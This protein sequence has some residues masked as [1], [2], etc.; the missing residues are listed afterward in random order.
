MTAPV[1]ILAHR[2]PYLAQQVMQSVAAA[3][4]RQIFLACDGP[5]ADR[6]DEFELVAATR[7]ALEAGITWDARVERRYLEENLGCRRAVEAAI[8]WFFE[9]VDSGII[10]EEDCLPNQDFFAFCT[11][12]LERFADE[13]SVMQIAGDNSTRIAPSVANADYFFIRRTPIWGWATWRRAWA[14]YDWGLTNFMSENVSLK[15]VYANPRERQMREQVLTKIAQGSGLDSWG[16]IW[17]WSVS[18]SFG[19]SVVPAVNLVSNI[20][21]GSDATHTTASQDSRSAVPTARIMPLRHPRRIRPSLVAERQFIRRAHGLSSW[22]KVPKGMRRAL[23]V[24]LRAGYAVTNRCFGLLRRRRRLVVITR[25]LRSLVGS[26]VFSRR[27]GDLGRAA[28]QIRSRHLSPDARAPRNQHEVLTDVTATAT[29]VGEAHE[30]DAPEL[31]EV[32]RPLQRFEQC[33]VFVHGSWADGTRTPF[34]DLDNLILINDSQLSSGDRRRI[35]VALAKV[36]LNMMRRDPLQHHGNWIILESD[37]D[38]LDESY[39]PLHVLEGALCLQGLPEVHARVPVTSSSE[40][41]RRNVTSLA[42][43]LRLFS[44]PETM[45]LWNAKHLVSGLSLMP[46]YLHQVHGKRISKKDALCAEAVRA[47][48]SATGV[49]AVQWATQAR[50]DW[51]QQLEREEFREFFARAVKLQSGPAIRKFAKKS[52]PRP[53]E[54]FVRSL[55]SPE[56]EA[57]I[58]ESLLYAS[59]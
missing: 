14:K 34:S 3:R 15:R 47:I 35:S 32:H 20:G 26:S 40:R 7:E 19:L 57:L 44:H 9:H 4:P 27:G 49:Q 48:F 55:P 25:A 53:T 6:A 41:M 38:G 24:G 2:R 28:A 36:D 13:A 5:R 11:E 10:L 58:S 33:R 42:G 17:S 12:L 45:T 56:I 29:R 51:G 37:F 16:F 54:G 46:A 18:S 30:L 21:F 50:R 52:A 43:A 39:L 22:R 1:L 23:R 59:C 8:T 31:V